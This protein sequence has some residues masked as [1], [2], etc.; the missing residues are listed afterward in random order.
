MIKHKFKNKKL[1][2]LLSLGMVATIGATAILASCNDNKNTPVKKVENKNKNVTVEANKKTNSDVSKNQT[3]QP[4]QD[5]N[6]NLEKNNQQL[7]PK[8]EKDSSEEP[9]KPQINLNPDDKKDQKDQKPETGS[10]QKEQGTPKAPET[11]KE[12]STPEVKTPEP[13][14][15]EQDKKPEEK[16]EGMQEKNEKD[17]K[18][19]GQSN[20]KQDGENSSPML[21]EKMQGDQADQEQKAPEERRLTR[22][23]VIDGT[24]KILE[25]MLKMEKDKQITDEQI[26]H[27]FYQDTGAV[28]PE[29]VFEVDF[30]KL[31]KTEDDDKLMTSFFGPDYKNSKNLLMVK[32]VTKTIWRA[33]W[34]LQSRE[35]YANDPQKIAD[36]ILAKTIPNFLKENKL[37]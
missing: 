26:Q 5:N 36:T 27:G 20:S 29:D 14:A 18:D 25:W 35:F 7:T 34:A 8:V 13:N 28:K 19:S 9:I 2:V 32:M 24:K 3:N 17:S 37:F 4:K 23:E 1:V 10:N 16:Q 12:E 6:Q 33:Y 15:S 11:K 30:K 21:E 22:E 31:F